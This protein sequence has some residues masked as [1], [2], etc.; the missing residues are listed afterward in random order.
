MATYTHRY[1]Y[2]KHIKNDI[3]RLIS[4]KSEYVYINVH[5]FITQTL[6]LISLGP[7][8]IKTNQIKCHC[9]RFFKILIH[10]KL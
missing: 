2:N 7:Q 3:H 1:N 5:V 9:T 6:P 10:R 8:R 4:T